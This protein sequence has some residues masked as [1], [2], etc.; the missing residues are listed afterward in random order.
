[1]GVAGGGNDKSP[2]PA[3]GVFGAPGERGR[4]RREVTAGVGGGAQSTQLVPSSPTLLIAPE[5]CTRTPES[6]D[7][8]YFPRPADSSLIPFRSQEIL[9]PESHR[10]S[11]LNGLSP[12]ISS[13]PVNPWSRPHLSTPTLSGC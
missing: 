2:L 12:T 6:Q 3:A 4:E 8:N 5:A 11:P 9:H 13:F 1:M 7:F 10:L